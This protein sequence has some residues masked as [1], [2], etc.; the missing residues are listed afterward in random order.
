MAELWPSRVAG[1]PHRARSCLWKI[2]R[3]VRCQCY[4]FDSAILPERPDDGLIDQTGCL[5]HN[6][7]PV[8]YIIPATLYPENVYLNVA[9]DH[10]S[11]ENA[12]KW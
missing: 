7:I 6:V 12:S 10:H 8:L 2:R 5:H 11:E 9:S 4:P 1:A 3:T